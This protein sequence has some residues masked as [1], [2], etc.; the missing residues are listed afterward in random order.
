MIALQWC[1]T[2]KV[3]KMTTEVKMIKAVWD[4][5]NGLFVKVYI[6]EGKKPHMRH[7]YGML[8]VSKQP[9]SPYVF[10]VNP[11]ELAIC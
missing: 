10:C 7:N 11:E 8:V 1:R 4:R 6:H 9:N 3:E 5:G 2:K